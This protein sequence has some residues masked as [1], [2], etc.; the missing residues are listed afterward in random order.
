MLSIDRH[1]IV[2]MSSVGCSGRLNLDMYSCTSSGGRRVVDGQCCG[3][4]SVT[5]T[6]N[7][8]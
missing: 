6:M 1:A 4:V 2:E 7:M 8:T 3:V 5:K